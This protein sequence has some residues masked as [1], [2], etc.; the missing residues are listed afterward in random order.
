MKYILKYI[1]GGGKVYE[2]A[3]YE[4]E[5]QTDKTIKFKFIEECFYITAHVPENQ[6][7]T[8]FKRKGYTLE[9]L[10][11]CFYPMSAGVPHWFELYKEN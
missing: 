9:Y 1:S 2:S 6:D 7:L 11:T 8:F 4:L 3:I 5:K 10:T